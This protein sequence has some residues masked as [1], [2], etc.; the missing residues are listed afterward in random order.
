MPQT[1]LRRESMW[2]DGVFITI[3]RYMGNNLPVSGRRFDS[4]TKN[5]DA[6]IQRINTKETKSQRKNTK[7]KN[8]KASEF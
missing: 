8:S 4:R 7:K 1:F 5:Q 3:K 6:K 2:I